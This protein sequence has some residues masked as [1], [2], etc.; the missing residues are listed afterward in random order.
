MDISHWRDKI[1]SVDERLVAL[2]NERAGYVLEIGALKKQLNLPV[3][4]PRREMEIHGNIQRWNRG[5]L[6]NAALQRVFERIIDE[7]RAIQREPMGQPRK[8]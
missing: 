2:L 1:D 3:H 8:D 7:G 5:P 4:E 6:D